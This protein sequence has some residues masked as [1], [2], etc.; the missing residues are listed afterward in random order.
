MPH[1][2]DVEMDAPGEP[3]YIGEC[4]TVNLVSSEPDRR[5]TLRQKNDH[6]IG[7]VL[8]LLAVLLWTVSGFVMQILYRDGYDKPFLVTY[9]VTGSYSLYLVPRFI[10][11]LRM[12]SADSAGGVDEYE[13]LVTS[14][15]SDE[16]FAEACGTPASSQHDTLTSG[17][18][19]GDI[20]P[21]S[22]WE[23]AET[24]FAFCWLWFIANWTINA[25]LN[26][27]TVA[28]S[29]VIASTSG[30]FTLG[31]GVFFGV[32]RFTMPKLTAVFTSFL[33]VVLVSLSDSQSTLSAPGS[34]S[35]LTILLGI[36]IHSSR[37]LFGD[38]LALISAFF[39]AFYVVFLKIQV[40]T[41]SRIDMQLFLG[42][43]GLFDLLTCCTVGMI[44][45]WTGVEKFEFPGSTIQWSALLATAVILFLGDYLL[46]VALLKT[47]PL[48]A[49]IGI[50]LTIPLA[51]LGDFFLNS[52]V[53]GQVALGALLVLMSFCFIALDSSKSSGISRG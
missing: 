26:Y 22:F 24:A 23:T 14:E 35:V 20:V 13:S 2:P 47:T 48:L 6:T 52:L 19:E 32:E 21:L 12:R 33:G 41:E 39:Y 16:E 15:G 17:D 51:V 28:S 36:P 7:V 31:I 10:Q 11:W 8:F 1:F 40:K 9:V 45:H 25:S 5:N 50:G 46:F 4:T 38:I 27:T 53:G 42:F 30:F 3:E 43:V 18:R 34:P 44:L 49:T 37:R 29:T